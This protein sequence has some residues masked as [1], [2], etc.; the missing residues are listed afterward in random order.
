[1][2]AIGIQNS[3]T[4]VL[5]HHNLE[6][7][8]MLKP[9]AEYSRRAAIVESVR[10]GRSVTETIRFFGYPRSTV[11]DVIAKYH[12]SEKSNKG[13]ATPARKIHSKERVV[14]TPD[15]IQRAQ[16]LIFEDSGQS[17][18]KLS[19]VVGVSEKTMRRIVEEDLRYNSYTIKVRQMLSEAARTKRV[20]RCNLLLC[21]LKHNAAGRLKFFSDE[22][23]FT[24][25][26]KINQR[27]DHWLAHNPEDVPIAR[28]KF[29]A[30]VHVL[31]VVSSEGDVMSPYFF[32]K[33]ENVTKEVYLRVLTN[34]V[35]PWIETVS[36]GK[37]YVF[38]QNGAP[39]H[40]SHLVQNWLSD[41]VEMFW[42]KEFWPPNSPDLNPLDFY[43]WDVVER[44]TN[45]S[46][47]PNV[48]SLR[49]A[50]ETA[51]TDMDRDILKR[52]CA[53]FRPR[54]EAVIQANGG[55]IE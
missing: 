40:T 1:M 27:N 19:S 24:V 10:A 32:N 21:S 41:N 44:V 16:E 28:T 39:A 2:F 29:P 15:I 18:R 26:A 25:D 45:K 12:E 52:A 3:L 36:S 48:A 17:I 34:V 33:G 51:F 7:V 54:M 38:Q 37:P 31:G 55:Y 9:S 23:I 50:I 46:R 11:Y 6:T 4:H 49:A 47:H 14:R 5:N 20:E 35:K 30:N 53:R 13:S 8:A 43:V 42:S 22:K